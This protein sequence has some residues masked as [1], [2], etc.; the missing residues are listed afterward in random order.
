[1]QRLILIITTVFLF[2]QAYGVEIQTD[3]KD[4]PIDKLKEQNSQIVKMVVEE[5]GKT[6]PQKVDKYTKITKL[7][8]ENLTLIYTF[9][10]NST[11]ES[12]Q[13]IKQKGESKMKDRIIKGVCKSSKRFIDSD[14][15]LIYEYI[16]AKSKQELF[17]FKIDKKV[18]KELDVNY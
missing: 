1:M 18:C 4:Y 16:S 10:I 15:S 2:N 3:M 9:E 7:R 11:K 14:I 8:D 6:L 13:E 12:D 17:S 5:V